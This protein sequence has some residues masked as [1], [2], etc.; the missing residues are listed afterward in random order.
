MLHSGARE[1]DIPGIVLLAGA[2]TTAQ[3]LGVV[4]HLMMNCETLLAAGHQI[5]RFASVL[6]ENGKWSIVENWNNYEIRYIRADTSESYPEI[7][8]ASLA[9]CIAVLRDLSGKEVVP[10]E[11]WFSH[12]DPGYPAVYEQVFGLP[13]QFDKHECRLKISAGDAHSAIPL[14][15][16]YVHALLERHAKAL[17]EKLGDTDSVSSTVSQLVT[18]HLAG[19][20]VDIEWISTQMNMSRWTLTRHLKQEGITFNELVKDLRSKPAQRYLYDKNMSI[21]EVGFLLGYSEPSAF[22][23]AFRGWYQCTPSEFR[24]R[25]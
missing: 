16:T 20:R 3:S 8:E 22:Q 13:V 12:P 4:G 6:S 5:A 24:T 11:V 21:S 18:K 25:H 10:L 19:G 1:I 9:A 23:R 15:Q 7:E 2:K 17:L 14:Q